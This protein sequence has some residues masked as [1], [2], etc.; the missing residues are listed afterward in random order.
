VK[1]DIAFGFKT[2]GYQFIFGDGFKLTYASDMVGIPEKSEKYF[3]K[4]DLLIT[5]GDGWKSNLATHYGI[6]PFME[7][8]KDKKIGKIYFTQIGR[9]VPNYE[10]AQKELSKTYPKSYITYDSQKVIF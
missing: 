6:W 3:D 9:P 4:I 10:E 7:K 2:V 8:I 1:H 5:D